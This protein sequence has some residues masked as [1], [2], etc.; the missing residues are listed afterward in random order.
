MAVRA[1]IFTASCEIRLDEARTSDA[2][3]RVKTLGMGMGSYLNIQDFEDKRRKRK[4]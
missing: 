1:S 3:G 4:F 2:E